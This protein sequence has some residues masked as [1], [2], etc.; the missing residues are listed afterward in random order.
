[1]HQKSALNYP[2]PPL[3]HHTAQEQERHYPVIFALNKEKSSKI[4][5]PSYVA[6]ILYFR[7]LL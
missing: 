7:L 1:M 4:P 6:D 5:V 2:M 3:K